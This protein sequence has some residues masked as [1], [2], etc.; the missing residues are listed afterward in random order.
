MHWWRR[1]VHAVSC[2]QVNDVDEH[3]AE[4]NKNNKAKFGGR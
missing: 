2:Y 1:Q 3:Q 4:T